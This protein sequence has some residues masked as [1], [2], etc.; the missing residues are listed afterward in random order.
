[1]KE[2]EDYT[3]TELATL[4]TIIGIIIASKYDVE[5]QNVVANFLFSVAQ[6][7][8]IIAA[9]N[10]NLKAKEETQNVANLDGTNKNLQKQMD[11]LKHQMKDFMDNSIH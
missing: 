2:I 1:M 5:Q 8:F 6:S 11:E 10:Q 9:Q 7:I 3:P 4:A